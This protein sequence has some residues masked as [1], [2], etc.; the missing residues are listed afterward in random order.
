M[1]LRHH[2]YLSGIHK[3]IETLTS[4]YFR[5]V[6]SSVPTFQ[7]GFIENTGEIPIAIGTTWQQVSEQGPK[8]K[9]NRAAV[10]SLI[11]AR[12]KYQSSMDTTTIK[13]GLSIDTPPFVK[14]LHTI[15]CSFELGFH[16]QFSHSLLKKKS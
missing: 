3:G 8:E 9:G 7:S 1:W 12:I 2:I 13:Y 4:R 6:S 16:T 14:Y 5:L 10:N 11:Y 15:N